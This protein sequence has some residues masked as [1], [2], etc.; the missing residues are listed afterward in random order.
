MLVAAR[1]DLIW[2]TLS[3]AEPWIQGSRLRKA[4]LAEVMRHVHFE[5]SM[6][7]T[8]LLSWPAMQCSGEDR[9]ASCRVLPGCSLAAILSFHSWQCGTL[10][11]AP[12]QDENTRYICIGPVNK[13]IN[14]LAC[15]LEDPDGDAFKRS[16]SIFVLGLRSHVQEFA[17]AAGLDVNALQ[18]STPEQPLQCKTLGAALTLGSMLTCR[19]LA[20]MPDYLWLAED[21]MKMQ[22]CGFGS[23]ASWYVTSPPSL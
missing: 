23:N 7:H 15:W 18:Q 9:A 14:T 20:R 16:V 17:R 3:R 5:V 22:V 11:S 4:A 6:L 8:E 10:R 21:G 1:Q 13:T 12:L 19:H 2:W